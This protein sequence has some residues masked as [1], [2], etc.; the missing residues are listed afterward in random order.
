MTRH[1][2]ATRSLRSKNQLPRLLPLSA[3][4]LAGLASSPAANAQ[5]AASTVEKQLPAVTVQAE[6]EKAD[7]Y[8]A[9]TTRV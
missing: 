6:A 5:E 1:T 7:G 8:R 4:M 9:T 2:R 3:M